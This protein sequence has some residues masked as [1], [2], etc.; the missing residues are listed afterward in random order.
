MKG[1]YNEKHTAQL[2]QAVNKLPVSDS[3]KN[4]TYDKTIK[5]IHGN[6]NSFLILILKYKNFCPC[7][8]SDNLTKKLPGNS[9]LLTLPAKS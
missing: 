9:V 2:K 8:S 5:M 3:N 1:R 4:Q 6:S 7:Y